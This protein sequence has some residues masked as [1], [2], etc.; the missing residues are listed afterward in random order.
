MSNN[1]V[2]PLKIILSILSSFIGIQSNK[3]RERDFKSN[4]PLHFII[5]GVILTLVL[6][7][8][9]SLLVNIALDI[10]Q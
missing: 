10:Y 7:L 4:N 5:A 2:S 3:N 8:L 9:V 1:S 6:I